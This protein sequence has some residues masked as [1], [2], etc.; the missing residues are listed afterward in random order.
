MTKAKKLFIVYLS[1]FDSSTNKRKDQKIIQIESFSVYHST[2]IEEHF[3]KVKTQYE[4][5]S[6]IFFS[7]IIFR[8]NVKEIEILLD[9]N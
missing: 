4:V 3:K 9:I 1:S 5:K 6:F 7:S 8:I 2:Q